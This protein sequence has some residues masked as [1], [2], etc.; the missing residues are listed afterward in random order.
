ML[1]YLRICVRFYSPKFTH[2]IKKYAYKEDID[3][4]FKELR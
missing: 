3:G 2:F 1:K 4:K